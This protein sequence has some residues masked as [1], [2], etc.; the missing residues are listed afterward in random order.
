MLHFSYE[1]GYNHKAIGVAILG[2]SAN[3]S[4]P[5]QLSMVNS[6]GLGVKTEDQKNGNLP[7]PSK[8][9]QLNPL[10]VLVGGAFKYVLCSPRKR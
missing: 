8:G 5:M 2:K 7:V 10:K 3:S 4:I 1:Q 6:K 9:C